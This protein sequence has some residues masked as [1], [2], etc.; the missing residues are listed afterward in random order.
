[1]PSFAVV[2]PAQA[3]CA[4]LRAQLLATWVDVTDAGGAVG[5]VAP[6]D[7]AAIGVELDRALDR[8]ARGRDAMGV[9]RLGDAAVGMGFLW[10][11]S[12]AIQHHWRTVLR[13]MVRP[14]LQSAGAGRRLLEGLHG[15]ARELGL[16]HLRLTVRGGTGI[17]RFYSRFGYEI[18]GRHPGALRLGPGDDRDE[19]IM[20]ARL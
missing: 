10:E 20:V 5:F 4:T 6:A 19:I 7:P 1:M 8:V 15:L 17:E 11:Q 3:R 16:E 14:E 13:V 9:L 2:D 12:S 18:V